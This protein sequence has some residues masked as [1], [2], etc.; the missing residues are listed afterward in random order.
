MKIQ[1]TWIFMLVVLG[2][3][4]FAAEEPERIS[5]TG[6]VFVD[7]NGNGKRDNG[8]PPLKA[9]VVSN[10]VDVSISDE[11]GSYNLKTPIEQNLLFVSIPDG[12]QPVGS[13]WKRVDT[14]KKKQRIDF[15]LQKTN[16]VKEFQFVH[17][18]DTHISQE[19]FV[20]TEK[21]QELIRSVKP[22][23]VLITGDLVKDALRVS[24]QEAR[25][26]YELFL[27]GIQNA[28]APIFTVPG[29]H[30]IFGIE[31]HLSS[32]SPGHP[33]Y[34]KKMYRHYLGPNYYSFNYGGIH[35]IGMDSVDVDDLWYYGHLD[36]VQ[37]DWLKKDLESIPVSRP[38]VTFNHIPLASAAENLSGYREDPPAPTLIK[39]NGQTV[40]RHVVSNAEAVLTELRKHPFPLALGGHMHMRESLTYETEKGK[41]RFHQSAAVVGPSSMAGMQLPSG[42]TVYRVRDGV[43]DEGTFISIDRN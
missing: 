8:E 20:R 23:F 31:R 10:Q 5:I 35:F 26:Y 13:F 18:S 17:A 24:E 36:Q 40:F 9:V 37:L 11:T 28:P 15:P 25:G 42:I 12:Y 7:D 33:M 4:A 19:S 16:S 41:T 2:L 22:A 43:I 27:K 6:T 14:G 39:V 21:L 34:G 3:A 32:I 29:N 38:V 30:E 1:K